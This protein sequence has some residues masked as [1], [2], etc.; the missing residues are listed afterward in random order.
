MHLK[1][2]L[3]LRMVPNAGLYVSVTRRCPLACAHCSTN[4]SPHARQQ[5]DETLI[6]RFLSTFTPAVHPTVVALTG[7]EALLRPR[8]VEHI[9]EQCHHTGASVSLISGMFFAQRARISSSIRR[10]LESVDHFTASID[11]F[12]EARVSRHHVFDVIHYMISLGKDVSIQA[13][14]HSG[15]D[16]YLLDL[17]KEVRD[18]FKERVPMLIE[19]VQPIGRAKD[20]VPRSSTRQIMRPCFVASWPVIAFD[21]RIVACCNQ[22]VV[23]GLAHAPHLEL[24]HI[25]D[26][27]WVDIAGENRNRKMLQYIRTIGPEGISPNTNNGSI[28][29]TCLGLDDL[30]KEAA[31][32]SPA[33]IESVAATA[34]QTAVYTTS[35]FQSL[36]ELGWEVAP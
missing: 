11:T 19:T 2:L 27:T 15:D 21:G 29:E 24:G 6:L 28:C 33:L 7:G 36:T 10:I 23:D 35:D 32:I 3:A 30:P 25:E 1:E 13:T 12:H 4:S 5:P 18:V 17:I 22:A 31:S 26:T 34:T 9:L 14:G 16:P 8:L 20:W